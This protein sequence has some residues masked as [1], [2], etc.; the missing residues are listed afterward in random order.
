MSEKAVV[1]K[2]D[3]SEKIIPYRISPTFYLNLNSEKEEWEVEIHLPGV[4]KESIEIKVLE[5]L[6]H[7]EAKQS[8]RRTYCA[9]EAFP[10]KVNPDTVKAQY[11]NG[12]LKIQGKIKNPLDEAV[13]VKIQ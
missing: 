3:S 9:T 7:L 2:T 13:D 10:F 5:D 8:E 12:L 6:I 1:E 11:E 4:K